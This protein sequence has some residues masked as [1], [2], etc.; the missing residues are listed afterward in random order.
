M[1]GPATSAELKAGE[2]GASGQPAIEPKTVYVGCAGWSI[3]REYAVSFASDGTHLQRYARTFNCC[4]INSS[5]YRPHRYDTWERWARSVPESFRFSAKLPR[6]ITHDSQL[7]CTPDDLTAFLQQVR[8]VGEKLGVLLV[9]LPPSCVF[10]FRVAKRF[11]MLFRAQHAGDIALEARHASWFEPQPEALLREF[12][13]A[14][15]AADPACVPAAGRPTGFDQIAYFRLHGSPRRYYSSYSG[16]FLKVAA[17]QIVDLPRKARIWCIFDNT[18][19]GFATS[20]ALQLREE[21]CQ[22]PL[23]YRYPGNATGPQVGVTAV[24]HQ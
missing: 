7:N 20:N 4:E 22:E 13:I 11:F 16:E 15:V 21:I 19:A 12:R 18:A 6:A 23:C 17:R 5:F 8:C 2:R 1:R 24:C 3:P 14:G 10:E 9:Q